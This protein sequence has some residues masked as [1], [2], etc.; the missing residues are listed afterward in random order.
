MKNEVSPH[1]NS[2]SQLTSKGLENK[3]GNLGE[4][5][6]YLYHKHTE[7]KETENPSIH[8]IEELEIL[9][10]YRKQNPTPVLRYD[11]DLNIIYTNDEGQHFLEELQNFGTNEKEFYQSIHEVFVNEENKILEIDLIDHV[12]RVTF[13]ISRN[14]QYVNIH[15]TDITEAKISQVE[16]ARSEQHLKAFLASVPDMM[17]R[18]NIHGMF[19]DVKAGKSDSLSLNKP[20]DEI[21]GTNILKTQ[22]ANNYKQE[23]F[24]AIKNSIAFDTVNSV[25][26]QH[27]IDGNTFFFEARIVKSGLDEAVCTVRDITVKKKFDLALEQQKSF[28]ENILNNLPSDII[29]YDEQ[30]KYRFINPQAEKNKKTRKWLIGKD[31]VD[32]CNEKGLDISIAEERQTIFNRVY[33]FKEID[34]KEEKI[35]EKG[36]EIWQLRKTVPILVKGYDKPKYVMSYGM[37]ITKLKGAQFELEKA[38]KIAEKSVKAK[39]M[40]LANMSHEIRTPMNAILGMSKLLEKTKLDKEQLKYLMA[41][42]NSTDHLLKVINDILDFSKINSG[43]IELEQSPFDLEALI[44]SA[45]NTLSFNAQGNSNELKYTFDEKANKWLLGDPYR[46]K[47]IFI[48]LLSNAIKF[49]NNGTVELV[50]KCL[51]VDDERQKMR[52]EVI[53]NG[54]GINEKKLARIFESFSQEDQSTTRKYGGTGLGLSI[55]TKLV[56]LMGGQLEVKS[57]KGVGTTFWFEIELPIGEQLQEAEKEFDIEKYDFSGVKVLIAED[58]EFNQLF[59]IEILKFH[60]FEYYIAPNGKIA[61]ELANKQN[62]DIAF[63]DIQM[64]EMNGIDAC[65]YMTDVINVGYPI[66]ALT[67]NALKGDRENFLSVGFDGYMSKPFN[68]LEILE[69]IVKKLELPAIGKKEEVVQ[70]SKKTSPKKPAKNSFSFDYNNLLSLTKNDDKFA[71]MMLADFLRVTPTSIEELKKTFFKGNLQKLSTIAHKLKS[72]FGMVASKQIYN[73]LT[74]IEHE[75]KNGVEVEF[76]HEDIEE[77]IQLT[78]T[79]LNEVKE[80][81][82]T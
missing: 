60:S 71:K 64:P 31:D 13:F 16:L 65:K 12:Y 43:V 59:I 63:L 54:I 23:L 47:Q 20:L 4:N 18:I 5:M 35:L 15:G 79:M 30:Q 17:F 44:E 57:K 9:A 8:N 19:L 50:C 62:F 36:N 80:F 66:V 81:L 74:H 55:T 46:M 40:F 70:K 48:N 6:I 24:Q 82:E 25:D 32:L 29:V 41:I 52:I 2:T 3:K 51:E 75:L 42:Y 21:L 56:E 45:L 67:A 69:L 58:N 53:D 78:E 72:S 28:Y 10:D 76:I 14:K 33:N 38:K 68:E 39:D 77:F 61:C 34:I 26:Y 27:E 49:T 11:E 7:K 37:D 22:L 1:M 73:L